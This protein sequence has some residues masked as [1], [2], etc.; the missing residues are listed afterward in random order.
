MWYFNY[1]MLKV[2]HQLKYPLLQ[3]EK[4]CNRFDKKNRGYMICP[5]ITVSYLQIR[6]GDVPPGAN[7]DLATFCPHPR[8]FFVKMGS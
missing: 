7:R 5:H 3:E 2:Q 6:T 8:F 1:G 4:C